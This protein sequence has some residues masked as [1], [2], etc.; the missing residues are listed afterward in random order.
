MVSVDEGD[1]TGGAVPFFNGFVQ[2]TVATPA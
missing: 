1:G 2:T